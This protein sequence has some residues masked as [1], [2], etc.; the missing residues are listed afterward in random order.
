[1]TNRTIALALA[2]A[3]LASPALAAKKKT[4]KELC[5]QSVLDIS[6]MRETES[7]SKFSEKTEKEVEDLVEVATHLCQQGNFQYAENL[8]MI[9]RTM[10]ASE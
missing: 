5:L 2:A 6:E 10:L 8:L 1:M 3:L 7:T 9:A 4:A